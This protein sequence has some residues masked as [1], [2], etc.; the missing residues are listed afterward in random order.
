MN[1]NRM[2]KLPT[3][4]DHPLWQEAVDLYVFVKTKI[5]SLKNVP[6][7]LQ[8]KTEGSAFSCHSVIAEEFS[9]QDNQKEIHFSSKPLAYLAENYSQVYA[10]FLSGDIDKEWFDEYNKK[11]LSLE[12]KLIPLTDSHVYRPKNNDSDNDTLLD[13]LY[14]WMIQ[15]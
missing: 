13:A 14:E 3:F 5:R 7:L 2:T 9:R 11:H 12:N 8:E 1:D 10:L 15:E 6:Q 4:R